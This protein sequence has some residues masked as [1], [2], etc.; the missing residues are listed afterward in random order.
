MQADWSRRDPMITRYLK[1]NGRSG[2][3]LYMVYSPAQPD[4]KRLPTFLSIDAVTGALPDSGAS[5]G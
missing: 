4:G 3:P 1:K 5:D 2:V